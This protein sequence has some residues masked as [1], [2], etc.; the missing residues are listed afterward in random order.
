MASRRVKRDQAKGLRSRGQNDCEEACSSRIYID[1]RG[2][3]IHSEEGLVEQIICA[4]DD[5]FHIFQG[6]CSAV[7]SDDGA[8]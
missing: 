3:T 5:S 4:S 1:L 6:D 8:A 7:Q 2:V